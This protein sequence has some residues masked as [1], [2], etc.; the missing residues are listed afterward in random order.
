[1]HFGNLMHFGNSQPSN[2]GRWRYMNSL[3]LTTIAINISLQATL[4]NA[5][6]TLIA[7]AIL[8]SLRQIA[9]FMHKLINR[10]RH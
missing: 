9:N 1:M 4:S 10:H 5:L 7:T 3:F 6:G 8:F 2:E